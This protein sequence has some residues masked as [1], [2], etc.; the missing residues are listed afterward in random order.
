MYYGGGSVRI[1]RSIYLCITYV[2][3]KRQVTCMQSGCMK[4]I[5]QDEFEL[6][7]VI[8]IVVAFLRMDI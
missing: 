4:K 5:V 8:Y 2:L 1:Y 6:C 3:Y 7:L